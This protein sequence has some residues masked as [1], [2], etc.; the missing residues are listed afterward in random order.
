MATAMLA[1]QLKGRTSAAGRESL[2]KML[3]EVAGARKTR[4][5]VFRLTQLHDSKL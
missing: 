5:G 1:F 3:G 4:R 2:P